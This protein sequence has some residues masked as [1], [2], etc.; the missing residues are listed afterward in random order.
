MTPTPE[1]ITK[2]REAF[3]AISAATPMLSIVLYAKNDDGGYIHHR[4]ESE[5]QGYLRD[6]TKQTTEIAALKAKIAEL[7][8]V[9][10]ALSEMHHAH[11][12]PNWFTDRKQGANAQFILWHGR[13]K[14][15]IEQLLKD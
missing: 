4:V 13:A 3:E 1:Q 15:T 8:N 9:S 5:W 6:K 11:F 14:A 12:N 7:D 10:H 2:W